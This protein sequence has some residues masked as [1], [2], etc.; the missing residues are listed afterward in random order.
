[1]MMMGVARDMVVI[2]LLLRCAAHRSPYEIRERVRACW[3]LQHGV[4]RGCHGGVRYG[5]SFAGSFCLVPVVR[6][7]ALIELVPWCR[8]RR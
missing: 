1:V 3:H 7:S 5:R 2:C 4:R 6:G 8:C